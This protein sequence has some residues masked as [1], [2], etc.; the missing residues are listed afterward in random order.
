MT[1]ALTGKPFISFKNTFIS[2]VVPVFNEGDN[3]ESN[4]RLLIAEIE[5]YFS[6][7]EIL[8]VSDGSTDATESRI[9]ALKLEK[10]RLLAYEENKGKGYAVRNGFRLSKGDYIFFIDGGMELHPKELRIFLGLMALYDADIVIG[11]KRHPQSKVY[12][13]FYRRILSRVFQ[14]FIA[15]TFHVRVSDTQVGVKLFK[16]EVVSSILPFLEINR[17]GFDLE[18][19]SLASLL[20]YTNVL[21]APVQLDYFLKGERFIIKD[22]IHVIRVGIALLFDTYRLHRRLSDV[23]K[24]INAGNQK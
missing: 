22:L 7:Y 24:V 21:E 9:Q 4:L 3:I 18:I 17:Y 6:N 1:D 19:L 23:Q 15:K 8:I 13:P 20:G 11:S 2:V 5:P 10:V 14:G 12:Y 16:R